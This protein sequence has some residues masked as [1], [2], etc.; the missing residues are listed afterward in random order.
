MKKSWNLPK[1]CLAMFMAL[2][3]LFS[4]G[5]VGGNHHHAHAVEQ[6]PVNPSTTLGNILAGNYELSAAEKE[7]LKSGNLSADIRFEYTL[8]PEEA[9]DENR[10]VSINR[11]QKTITVAD[12]VDDE[13]NTWIPKQVLIKVN[14]ATVETLALAA[15]VC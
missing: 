15:G 2:A 10:L 8:P 7:V 12:F 13:G 4:S 11:E 9:T 14:D 3:V 5:Y 6:E 1:R